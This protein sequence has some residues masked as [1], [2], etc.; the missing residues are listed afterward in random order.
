LLA[1]LSIEV[2]DFAIFEGEMKLIHDLP[3][4]TEGHGGS[5]RTIHAVGIGHA[6]DFFGGNVGHKAFAIRTYC[7]AALPD[8]IL[9]Q[10]HPQVGAGA[11]VV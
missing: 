11:F 8:V 2:Y 6:E 7:S 3:A 9:D 5:Q 10:M 1:H 4:H